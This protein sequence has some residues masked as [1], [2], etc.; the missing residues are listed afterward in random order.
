MKRGLYSALLLSTALLLGACGNAEDTSSKVEQTT[1]IKQL[2]QILHKQ[3]KQWINW[4]KHFHKKE[5]K[6]L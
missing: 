2:Q 5:M 1:K 4:F 6:M 3:M